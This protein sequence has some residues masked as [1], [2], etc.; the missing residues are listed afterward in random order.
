MSGNCLHLAWRWDHQGLLQQINWTTSI[1]ITQSREHQDKTLGD[2][3][4]PLQL[5]KLTNWYLGFSSGLYLHVVI[6]MIL[7]LNELSPSLCYTRETRQ[8]LTRTQSH[9]L[10]Q[11]VRSQAPSLGLTM[12]E[13]DGSAVHLG[14]VK[15]FL[16]NG[17]NKFYGKSACKAK[18]VPE[19]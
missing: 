13:T 19:L 11:P 12:T 1:R 16:R 18:S 14:K 8:S 9:I 6:A 5:Y 4:S 7:E 17:K 10:Y 15:I 3:A 2:I